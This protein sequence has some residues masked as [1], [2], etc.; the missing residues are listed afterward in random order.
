MKLSI[1]TRKLSRAFA[2]FA[3][4]A[5]APAQVR[6]SSDLTPADRLRWSQIAENTRLLTVDLE[7][8]RRLYFPTERARLTVTISNPTSRPLEVLEPL[9]RYVPVQREVEERRSPLVVFHPG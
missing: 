7:L 1:Q 9:H 5:L 6:E 4:V 2:I 8:D 3:A